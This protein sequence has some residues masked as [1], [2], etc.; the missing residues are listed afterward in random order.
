MSNVVAQMFSVAGLFNFLVGGGG[1]LRNSKCHSRGV[2][3]HAPPKA[4][5]KISSLG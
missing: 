5:C 2:W 4:F 1:I 3:G